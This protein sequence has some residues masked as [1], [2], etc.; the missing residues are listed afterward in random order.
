MAH[1]FDTRQRS[2]SDPTRDILPVTPNDTTPLPEGTTALYVEVGGILAIETLAGAV[3]NVSVSDHMILPVAVARV[4]ATG[5][6]A[7]GIH[8]FQY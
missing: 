1:I 2:F 5:T 7:G 3:R 4:L 6:T 8:A